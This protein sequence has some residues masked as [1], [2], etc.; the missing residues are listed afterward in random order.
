MFDVLQTSKHLVWRLFDFCEFCFNNLH[1]F[2]KT[3]AWKTLWTYFYQFHFYQYVGEVQSCD[4]SLENIEIIFFE[5]L[6]VELANKEITGKELRN[7]FQ[8][9]PSLRF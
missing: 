5:A 9:F 6:L 4:F 3:S 1:Q 8:F 2:L 7:N